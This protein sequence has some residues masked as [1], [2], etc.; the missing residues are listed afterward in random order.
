MITAR[1]KQLISEADSSN[2]SDPAFRR[3]LLAGM[4]PDEFVRAALDTAIAHKDS[5]LLRTISWVAS[6]LI[7]WDN[8]VP[9][10]EEVYNLEWF[11]GQEQYIEWIHFS[12]LPQA[13]PLMRRVIHDRP[14]KVDYWEW[15]SVA[16]KA[17]FCLSRTPGQPAKHELE[18]LLDHSTYFIGDNARQ[19]H[20][21]RMA[22]FPKEY[23]P[24]ETCTDAQYANPG[25]VGHAAPTKTRNKVAYGDRPLLAWFAECGWETFVTSTVHL[26][27]HSLDRMIV[28]GCLDSLWASCHL[29]G[30]PKVADNYWLLQPY[31]AKTATERGT[32]GT[33]ADR[34]FYAQVTQSALSLFACV[35]QK[36]HLVNGSGEDVFLDEVIDALNRLV[37]IVSVGNPA[38]ECVG[39]D[40]RDNLELVLAKLRELPADECITMTNDLDWKF[41]SRLESRLTSAGFSLREDYYF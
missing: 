22:R 35:T 8:H 34:E 28:R 27:W 32:F 14:I 12:N 31:L 17:I 16:Q 37:Q 39:Q 33:V 20:L 24:A 4:Q 3:K 29:N 38:K 23:S 2:L 36:S 19:R 6:D 5:Q 7:T 40:T 15:W 10:I 1:Q 30:S 18:Q 9:W 25:E 11:D 26:E 13:V 41:G 21:E